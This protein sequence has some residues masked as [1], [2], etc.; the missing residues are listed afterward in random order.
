M[1]YSKLCEA[2]DF[3]F[4]NAISE[5]FFNIRS[6]IRNSILQNKPVIIGSTKPISE[7]LWHIKLRG[8]AFPNGFY[9]KQLPS[10]EIHNYLKITIQN[11][12]DALSEKNY[13]A[14][15]YDEIKI[16]EDR[17]NDF[18]RTLNGIFYS[19]KLHI[20]NDNL[21]Q[22]PLDKNN[23]LGE[24]SLIVE[25]NSPEDAR[26]YKDDLTNLLGYV[27][28]SQRNEPYI[29]YFFDNKEITEKAKELIIRSGIP[30]KQ[31][32]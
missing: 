14:E 25:F 5:Y 28:N 9:E 11:I 27:G 2:S 22:N 10:E 20:H 21:N 6:I 13:L 31:L 3:F 17:D 12:F 19:F 26:K 23:T 7:N 4:K 16:E 29:D 15:I 1:K 30:F 18:S 8:R 24:E 32:I